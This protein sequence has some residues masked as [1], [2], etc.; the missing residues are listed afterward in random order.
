MQVLADFILDFREKGY[1]ATLEVIQL[2]INAM[3][4]VGV[5]SKPT[6]GDRRRHA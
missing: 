1:R 5:M 2:S 4:P 6:P 3:Q